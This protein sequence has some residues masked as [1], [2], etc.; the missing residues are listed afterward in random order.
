MTKWYITNRALI[1]AILISPRLTKKSQTAKLGG[2][3]ER[4]YSLGIHRYKR[5]YVLIFGCG[6]TYPSKVIL[7]S[8]VATLS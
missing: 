3:K 2:I 4:H 6:T 7:K 8:N 1:V 5:T